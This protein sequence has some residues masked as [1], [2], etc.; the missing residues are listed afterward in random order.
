VA[1][2]AQH[3]DRV[4]VTFESG[5]RR[6]FD[7]V[8]GADGQNSVVRALAW[9]D[10]SRYL[11]HLGYY[12]AIFT[13]PHHLRL[14][15]TGPFHSGPGKLAGMYSARRNTEAKAMFY[16][17]SEP[18][19]Y[20]RYDLAAQKKLLADAFVGVGWEVPRLLESMWTA[21]DFYFDSLS[22]VRM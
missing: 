1:S 4:E 17:A 21:S 9:G 18:L 19:D 15:H 2:L 22:Q 12:V 5:R 16:F 7:L 14:D 13:T 6:A 3:D 10:D 20:D 8:V 11:H